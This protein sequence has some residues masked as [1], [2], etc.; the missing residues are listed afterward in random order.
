MPQI[1]P[2]WLILLLLFS[3]NCQY[4]EEIVDW[5]GYN[6]SDE[7]EKQKTHAIDRMKFKRLQPYSQSRFELI[8]PFK[9]ELA[10]FGKVEYERLKPLIL[11]KTIPELQIFVDNGQLNYYELCLFYIYRIYHY[12]TDSKKY[13][14]AIISLNPNVLRQAK[15]RDSKRS[16]KMEHPIYGMPILLKDNINTKN[17]A[18]TAGSAFLEKN[19]PV[20]DAV[21]T[22]NLKQKGALILGKTNLSEW[23]YYFCSGCPLG[24]SYMGGQTLNPYVRMIFESGGS[25]SGSAVA[26]STNFA[27]V[28][29]GSETSGSI[30]SPSS[31][32]SVVGLK[33]TVGAISRSGIVPIS[34]TLDTAGPMTKSVI[35]NA[36]VM[37]ALIGYD[38]DDPQ[39]Y[40]AEPIDLDIFDNFSLS[41]M[42]FGV[43]Q[44]FAN[45]SLL[46]KAID[47]M[48]KNEADVVQ[49]EYP[50]ISLDGFTKLLD[51]DMRKDLSDY[52]NQ[53]GSTDLKGTSIADIISFNDSDSV[54]RAPYGQ[55]IFRTIE[56]DT[57]DS[58]LFQSRKMELMAEAKRYFED[59]IIQHNLDVI[60]SIN[61]F[62][63]SIAALAHFPALTIPM[64]FSS[65]GEP[66]NI[67]FI[68]PSKEEQLLYSV[69]AVFEDISQHR[70]P[71]AEYP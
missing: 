34:S 65:V 42:R 32:N 61:N 58:K 4:Q 71:P 39:S 25:S 38:P 10:R 47:L 35:D 46:D 57:L 26:V 41:G 40:H 31:K 24:Y 59:P 50:K 12:E 70:S 63:A 64:G 13:L 55:Q 33:P 67:T 27:V 17:I 60:L 45:D 51:T 22:Q 5:V 53:Y 29:I 30:L 62:S 69:G 20:D 8:D 9:K 66:F 43:S 52:F 56:A 7:I 68:A 16:Q 37:N 23:A 21:V 18:T 44:N 1:R 36:I 6:E 2:L 19:L 28:A 15:L 14:N 49:V 54:K 48:I 3:Y 11:E